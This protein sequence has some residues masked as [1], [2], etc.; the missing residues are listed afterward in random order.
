MKLKSPLGLS[1]T[2]VGPFVYSFAVPFII[3]GLYF[4]SDYSSNVFLQTLGLFLII[5]GVSVFTSTMKFLI[6]KFNNGEL[7]T[8]GTFGLSRNPLYSCWIILII[9][10]LALLFLNWWFLLGSLSMYIGLNL[11]IK[12]EEDKLEDAFGQEFLDYKKKVG[13][14]FL[15]I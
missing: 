15:K 1:P 5:V 4:P 9:P 13:R 2:G 3:L 8:T 12:K 11:L 14:V 10:G 6:S 7:A